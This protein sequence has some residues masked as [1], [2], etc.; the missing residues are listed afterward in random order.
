MTS[1]IHS[2]THLYNNKNL[3]FSTDILMHPLHILF[4]GQKWN[5]TKLIF[6]W[7]GIQNRIPYRVTLKRGSSFS[8]LKVSC[9]SPYYHWNITYSTFFLYT[10][11]QRKMPLTL[12]LACTCTVAVVQGCQL[13]R[14]LYLEYISCMPKSI[15]MYIWE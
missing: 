10:Y 14:I 8:S 4:P 9:C 6:L 15:Y 3:H 2:I 13:I 5:W 11:A 7:Y 1:R 12:K